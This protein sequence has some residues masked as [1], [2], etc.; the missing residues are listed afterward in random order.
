MM[1]VSASRRAYGQRAAWL[2]VWYVFACLLEYT[3]DGLSP[4]TRLDFEREHSLRVYLNDAAR[5]SAGQNR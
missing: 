4:S 5:N 1:R 2:L 3:K